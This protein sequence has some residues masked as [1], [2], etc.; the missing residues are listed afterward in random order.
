MLFRSFNLFVSSLESGGGIVVGAV[1][2]T[3]ISSW[4]QEP[5]V[6]AKFFLRDLNVVV[7]LKVIVFV[8]N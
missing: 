4:A 6:C 3:H 8:N 1:K 7:F 2:M 5:H